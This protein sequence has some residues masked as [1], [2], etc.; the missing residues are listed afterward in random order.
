MIEFDCVAKENTKE[1]IL[2]WPKILDH[3][4]RTLIIRLLDQ[5]K[6]MHYLI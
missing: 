5:E 6:E 3:L 2:N 4:Y 1:H